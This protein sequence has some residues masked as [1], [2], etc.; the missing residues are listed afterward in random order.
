MATATLY[1]YRWLLIRL[2]IAVATVV[3]TWFLWAWFYP[4]PES[5]VVISAGLRDGAYYPLARQY[6]DALTRRGVEAVV[7]ESEGSAQNLQ[8]LK[9]SPPAADMA[10]VQG[11]FGW[12][13]QSLD[14]T[15]IST[16]QTL[17]NVGI[18]A[19]WI[20]SRQ[21]DLHSILQLRGMRVAAGPEGSGHRALAKL[22]IQQQRLKPDELKLLPL[23]GLRAAEALAQGEADA[24]ILVAA[25]DSPTVGKLL[26]TPGVYLA[27][28]Q[29][30]VAIAERNNFLEPRLL[31]QD[32]LGPA[33]PGRDVTMLTT[34]THL[35]VRQDLNPALKRLMTAAAMEIQ[36]GSGPF[37][38]AGDFPALRR[39]DFPSAPEARQ[40]MGHGLSWLERSLPFWWAQIVERL[41]VVCIPLAVLAWWL[42]LLIPTWLRWKLESRVTRWYGELKF[43]END[44]FRQS[45]S[46]L[47]VSRLNS[48]LARM[49]AAMSTMTLPRELAQRW[50]TLHQHVEFVRHRIYRLR[51]R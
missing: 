34:H 8:R 48:R 9:A 28:L 49:D 30:T 33:M 36:T 42:S 43:I 19:V 38:R 26:R 51:G 6:A 12:S 14:P 44:L 41:V 45:L 25:A 39:S 5:R 15:A 1:R 24:V 29:R 31:A 22:L 21:R 2:P 35:V 18:E 17:A 37:H 40:V 10:L 20:F 11:G 4:M 7:L 50:Y 46:D 3:G 13:S 32:A 27:G 47:D 23:T 16:V